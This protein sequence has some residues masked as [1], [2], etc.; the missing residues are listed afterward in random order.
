M[1]GTVASWL[2]GLG[3]AYIALGIVF[4]V[5]FLTLG[6][7][8]VDPAAARGTVG[9]R[10]IVFPG[11]VALWPLLARRWYSRRLDDEG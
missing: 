2:V 9:F 7:G 8:R 6:I 4:A 3:A 11:A 5:P 10:I 1:A